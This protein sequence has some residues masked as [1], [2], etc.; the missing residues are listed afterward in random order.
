[1]TRAARA[2]AVGKKQVGKV[3]YR[4]GAKPALSLPSLAGRECDCS[5]FIR[6]L[7]HQVGVAI[8]D[9]SQQQKAACRPVAL[10]LALG[11]A[12]A[13]LLLFM[14]PKPGKA[15]PRHVALSLGNG[16]SLE[17]CSGKGVAVCRRRTWTS[18]GKIDK[19]MEPCDD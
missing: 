12:G 5:G 7:L 14:S 18:A 10:S 1:V 4:L 6:W 8:V 9:G 16:E 15:W 2:I 13:G 17:C 19:L 11:P 3:T